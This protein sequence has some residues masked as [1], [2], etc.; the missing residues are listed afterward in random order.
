MIE[1]RRPVSGDPVD[2]ALA[3]LIGPLTGRPDVDADLYDFG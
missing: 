3:G 1:Q 2:L